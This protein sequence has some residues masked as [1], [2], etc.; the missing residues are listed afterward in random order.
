MKH[1]LAV[2]TALVM[3]CAMLACS[4]KTESTGT[5]QSEEAK[6][7]ETTQPVTDETAPSADV[8]E[9]P[10]VTIRLGYLPEVDTFEDA[11]AKDFKEYVESESNGSITVVLFPG[12]QLGGETE[13]TEQVKMGATEMLMVGELTAIDAVPAYATVLRVPYLFDSIEHI[14]RFLEY[15]MSDTGLTIPEMVQSAIGIRTLGY[16][17]RGSRQ[18]TSNKPVYSVEDLYGLKLRVPS[19][20]ISVAAWK[21]TGAV[22]TAI[23]AGELYLALQQGLVEAQENPVDFIAGKSLN[24]VQKYLIMTNHQYGMRWL[25]INNDFFNSLTENQQNILIEA[26]KRYTE[27]GNKLIAETEAETT[28]KLIDLGMILIPTTEID[29]DSIKNVILAHIDELGADWSPSAMEAVEATR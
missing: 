6:T 15:P 28:Q 20:A 24:E 16:Y 19:V 4:T 27:M 17:S 26:G 7:T 14:E 12:G 8:V 5:T 2:I 25:M 23:E 10:K 11:V 1:I 29:I 18:L 22:P 21:E 13:M 3:A 9:D